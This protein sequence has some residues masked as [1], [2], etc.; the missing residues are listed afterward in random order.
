MLLVAFF[1]CVTRGECLEECRDERRIGLGKIDALR[2]LRKH[3]A[4][5][6]RL[7]RH[8]FGCVLLCE[9]RHHLLVGECDAQVRDEGLLLLC[10]GLRHH[11]DGFR[12]REPQVGGTDEHEAQLCVAAGVVTVEV[13]V[14]AA[15]P[16]QI[17]L[18]SL[19]LRLVHAALRAA[20]RALDSRGGTGGATRIQHPE[21]RVGDLRARRE[22]MHPFSVGELIEVPLQADEQVAGR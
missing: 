7:L 5:G 15:A 19:S 16:G 9:I 11:D 6:T 4:Q 10:L 17:R 22:V 3:A 12:D 13:R 21:H 1:L 8:V 14:S 2:V 20:L 18:P